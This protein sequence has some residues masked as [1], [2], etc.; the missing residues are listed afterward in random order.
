ME[1]YVL[2]S[3]ENSDQYKFVHVEENGY[4]EAYKPRTEGGQHQHLVVMAPGS[5]VEVR[6]PVVATVHQ[7]DVS[8]TVTASNQVR[9]D[10]ETVTV[11]V[12]G[13]GVAISDHTSLLLDLSNRA[14]VYE[15][16]DVKVRVYF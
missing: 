1:L 7:G 14:N 6:I 15:F 2:F 5:S 16:I 10:K 12:K 9:R 13:E 4:V 3:L 8:V 11:T